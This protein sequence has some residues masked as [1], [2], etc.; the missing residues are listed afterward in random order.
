MTLGEKI[1]EARRQA[2]LTQE[3]LADKLSVSRPAVAKWETD[4]G[5]P[6]V[7]NLKAVAALLN[8][9]V[10][11]L[12]DD[13]Q[14]ENS[15]ELREA[16]DLNEYEKTGACRCREDA[17]VLAKYPD[18]DFVWPLMREKK[19]SIAAH[20]MEFFTSPGMLGVVDQLED[21]SWY[22]LVEKQGVQFLVNVTKE[23]ITSK[24]MTAPVTDRRFTV[25]NMCY[26][27]VRLNLAAKK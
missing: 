18:A 22:Y 3:Q 23:F 17:V 24:R 5:V 4:K 8:V 10:D 9:S 13:G 7:G 16:I 27:R 2:G 14:T 26:T 12:L 1:R 25:G 11:Y 19:Q 21:M 6:D 20:I 15:L